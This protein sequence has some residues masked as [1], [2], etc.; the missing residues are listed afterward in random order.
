M[1]Y[2]LRN[3]NYQCQRDFRSETTTFTSQKCP[4][5]QMNSIDWD[6]QV[7][8]DNWNQTKKRNKW[9]QG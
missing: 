4:F 8:T 3:L 6:K 1:R 7:D 2:F 5:N 9:L